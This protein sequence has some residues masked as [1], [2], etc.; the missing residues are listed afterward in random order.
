MK[1]NC[2]LAEFAISHIRS[3]RHALQARAFI[4]EDYLAVWSRFDNLFFPCS[5][6]DAPVR[7]RH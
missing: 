6:P 1:M 7:S 4:G 5:I 3:N 2:Q